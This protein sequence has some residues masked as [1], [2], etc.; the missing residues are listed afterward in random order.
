MTEP[1]SIDWDELRLKARAAMG[2]AYAPYS[3]FP[4]GAAA[5]VV[6]GRIVVGCNV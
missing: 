5:L 3:N 4:V 6:A 2:S 1:L